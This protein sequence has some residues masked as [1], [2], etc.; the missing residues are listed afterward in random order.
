M[1]GEPKN[2]LEIREAKLF[3]DEEL[4]SPL[5]MGMDD[6]LAAARAGGDV[7]FE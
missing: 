6:M 7:V 2:R 4:P 1:R 5:A 3:R